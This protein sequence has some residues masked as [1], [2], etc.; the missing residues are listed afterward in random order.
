VDD[1]EEDV[2]GPRGI[3]RMDS[4]EIPRSP[5]AGIVGEVHDLSEADE[6][7]DDEV[8]FV[9]DASGEDDDDEE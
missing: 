1:D 7:D 3:P 4:T 5:A 8:T 6:D 2:E 9:D